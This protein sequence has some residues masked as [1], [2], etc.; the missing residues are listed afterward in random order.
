MSRPRHGLNP[1]QFF[2]SALALANPVPLPGNKIALLE[3]GDE[4]F[5]AM[6]SAIRSARRTIRRV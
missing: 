6:L 4:Y 3:N 2:G 5:P 1:I